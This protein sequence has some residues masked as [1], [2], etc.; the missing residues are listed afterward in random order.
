MGGLKWL[1]L[2]VRDHE[3]WVA[4]SALG[5]AEGKISI[6]ALRKSATVLRNFSAFAPAPCRGKRGTTAQ[7]LSHHRCAAQERNCA[8]HLLSL[9]PSTLSGKARRNS[10]TF[11]PSSLRRTGK[12]G[13][14]PPS[15]VSARGL[16]MDSRLR[17]NDEKGWLNDG[18]LSN[19][20]DAIAAI[21]S[22]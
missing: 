4:G 22:T 7:L 20:K 12:R 13:F 14:I 17:G 2:H 21:Y 6:A 3:K 16:E 10:A 15:S 9:S 11:L 19:L 5:K 8:A 18:P 1:I